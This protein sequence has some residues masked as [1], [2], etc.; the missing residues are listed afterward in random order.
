[1]DVSP[2]VKV[3]FLAKDRLSTRQQENNHITIYPHFLASMILRIP[4]V[5][6]ALGLLSNSGRGGE[7]TLVS[8]LVGLVHMFSLFSD[9]PFVMARASHVVLYNPFP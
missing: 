9:Q 6:H 7:L 8:F 4:R 2:P 5:R 3:T 1:M